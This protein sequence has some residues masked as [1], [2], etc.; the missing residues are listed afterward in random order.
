M[1]KNANKYYLYYFQVTPLIICHVID[2]KSP[3]WSYSGKELLEQH[4]EIVVLLEGMVE[5]TGKIWCKLA[6]S[7]L[8]RS[9][10]IRLYF[11][12]DLKKKNNVFNLRN[13]VFK[14]MRPGFPCKLQNDFYQ[15]Y[16]SILIKSII[17]RLNSRL[18]SIKFCFESPLISY[19][20]FQFTCQRNNF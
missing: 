13:S 3:F 17:L 4:Y 14:V 6:V 7:T 15:Q 19:K 5:A 20:N 1:Y 8:L 9:I 16:N 10:Q 11:I 18:N 12:I 2:N